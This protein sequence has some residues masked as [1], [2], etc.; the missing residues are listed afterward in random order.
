VTQISALHCWISGTV[1]GVFFRD[2]TR[3]RAR[4]LGLDGWVRNLPDGRV[5]AFFCGPRAAC[6]RALAFVRQGPPASRVSGVEHDWED[7]PDPSPAGFEIR[8]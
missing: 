3:Q 6:E 2:S 7:P 4:E 5:E 1:Q 8:Y